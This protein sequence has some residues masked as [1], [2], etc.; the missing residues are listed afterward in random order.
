MDFPKI[1]FEQALFG[2]CLLIYNDQ[3]QWKFLDQ[4]TT[5]GGMTS[6]Q[7][8]KAGRFCVSS[9]CT[10]AILWMPHLITHT[11]ANQP[12]WWPTHHCSAVRKTSR[13]RRTL[14]W[15]WVPVK[16]E[17]YRKHRGLRTRQNQSNKPA[18]WIYWSPIC[19]W[20]VGPLDEVS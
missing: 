12:A 9:P 15:K 11:S 2:G 4:Y 20:S 5:R 10:F 17:G 7:N 19:L 14:S 18:W 6:T 1:F 8:P 3:R 16:L 13:M